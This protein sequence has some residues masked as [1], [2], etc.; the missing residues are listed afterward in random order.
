MPTTPLSCVAARGS[1][2]EERERGRAPRPPRCAPRAD[3]ARSR[4]LRSVRQTHLTQSA[5]PESSRSTR[6]VGSRAVEGTRRAAHAPTPRPRRLRWPTRVLCGLRYP[7]RGARFVYVQHPGAER[8]W[9]PPVLITLALLSRR[10]G[11]QSMR[12]SPSPVRC[13]RRPAATTGSRRCCASCRAARVA[14]GGRAAR[15]GRASRVALVSGVVAAPFNDALSEAVERIVLRRARRRASASPK[16]LRD[17]GAHDRPRVAQARG[18]C[19]GDAAAVRARA[20]RAPPRGTGAHRGPGFVLTALYFA[21]DYVDS[22]AARREPVRA[23]ALRHG[24]W[25]HLRR[26]ARARRGHLAVRS[27][28]CVNVLFMPAA[29]AGG[30]LLF[31]GACGPR[32]RGKRPGRPNGGREC[33]SRTPARA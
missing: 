10:F 13:G 6:V 16:L 20:A 29:V 26:D 24:R 17:L 15:Y 11:S 33:G 30:T 25:R 1:R 23:P 9:L 4:A 32:G 18:V 5:K 27:C 2:Q 28:R 19:G 12:A 3:E 21:I 7:W 31:L 14:R 8:F 22:A